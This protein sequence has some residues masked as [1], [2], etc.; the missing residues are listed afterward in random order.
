MTDKKTPDELAYCEAYLAAYR[1]LEQVKAEELRLAIRKAQ[2]KETLKA[3]VPLALGDDYKVDVNSLTL[4]DAL[5]M[6]VAG[7]D[8]PLNATEFRCKLQDL[9]Y[10]L[11]QYENPLA[12]IHTALDRMVETD[13]L[14]LTK[15]DKKKQFEAGPE[16]KSVPELEAPP[17]PGEFT[18]KGE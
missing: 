3:L 11:D 13:E 2:L 16:L 7:S 14:V 17:P 5:R 15:K 6:V 18:K 12:S 10:N 8:R 9:R 1:E 4:A